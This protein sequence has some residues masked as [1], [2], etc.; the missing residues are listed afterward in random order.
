M[1]AN[2]GHAPAAGCFH[3]IDVRE[4]A[5]DIL[6][7]SA[8]TRDNVSVNEGEQLVRTSDIDYTIIRPGVMGNDDIPTVDKIC[9]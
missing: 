2:H 5:I 3:V 8:I 7:Q 6:P 9:K 1:A 4:R